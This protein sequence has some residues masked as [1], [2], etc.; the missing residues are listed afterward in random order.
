ML[1]IK[2]VQGGGGMYFCNRLKLMRQIETQ[3]FIVCSSF[4]IAFKVP[5]PI[6]RGTKI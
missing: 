2:M 1:N 3:V 6:K 5:S 4:V